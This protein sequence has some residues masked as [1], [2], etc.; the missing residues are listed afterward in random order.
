V[1]SFRQPCRR[2][3]DE[4][5]LDPLVEPTSAVNVACPEI[6][7][8]TVSPELDFA[9]TAKK[10]TSSSRGIRQGLFAGAFMVRNVR[11]EQ[12]LGSLM[13]AA[14]AGDRGAY[15]ELLRA[16]VPLVRE[17]VR[18]RFGFL[19]SQDVDDLVQDVLLAL[20]T[21]R[22]TYDPARPFLPW[23]TAIARHRMADSARRHFRRAAYEQRSEHS[24][25]TF[26]AEDANI[27]ANRYGDAEALAR[28]MTKLPHGQ[29]QAI[30]LMK[31]HEMS[32]KE[33]AAATGTSI[34]ALKVSVHRGMSA[35]RKALR[36]T[37]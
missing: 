6:S 28:A 27:S 21:S 7:L 8:D 10:V 26:S 34:G 12:H 4:E 25:G 19:Q 35:L 5:R 36:S 2:D 15:T 14:Q 18:R 30:E 16:L 24:P 37:D 11:E 23:L 22:A 32:L 20:H 1:V 31:L 29:R 9:S 17:A 13:H 33:A 3:I